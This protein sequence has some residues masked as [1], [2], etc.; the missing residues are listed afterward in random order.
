MKGV[1]I[2]EEIGNGYFAGYVIQIILFMLLT[3]AII[4][5]TF[6]RNPE[7]QIRCNRKSRDQN[8]E[9]GVKTATNQRQPGFEAMEVYEEKNSPRENIEP[10]EQHSANPQ[11]VT[12]S[13]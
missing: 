7:Y 5:F 2:D 4:Y 6:Q 9:M 10:R 1:G 13:V 12:Y 8:Q 3:Y 11:R